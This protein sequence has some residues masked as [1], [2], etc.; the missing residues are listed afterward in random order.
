MSTKKFEATLWNQWVY[1]EMVDEVEP[2]GENEKF[3]KRTDGYSGNLS[4]WATPSPEPQLNDGLIERLSRPLPFDHPIRSAALNLAASIASRFDPSEILF[5]SILRAGVPVADWLTRLLPG[6]L[7]VATS[8]FIGHGIDAVSLSNLRAEHP[9]R[10]IVFVDGWTGKGGV[11]RELRQL[12]VSPL[13][14]LSDPWG[15]AY[16]CG[17]RED[18]LS[19]SACFTGP[20]TLGFSRTFTRR[21][22]QCFAA[23]RFPKRFLRPEVTA[24]WMQS[25]PASRFSVAN[26]A[27]NVCTEQ[28]GSEITRFQLSAG[29][30]EIPLRVHSNEVCRA[31]INSNPGELWFADKKSTVVRD[32]ELLLELAD[33]QSIPQRFEVGD[34][35]IFQ[36]KVACTLELTNA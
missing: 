35:S 27:V 17:T 28:H 12:G 34:L 15:Q 9:D 11:A 18:V 25:C 23:Y 1:A 4:F 3:R 26:T 14:V 22:D 31:L 33:A 30:R 24:A 16:F 29:M 10:K 2:Y 21:S 36:A 6:S 19:P 8:L 32:Y 13:A 20:M 5:V 7:A